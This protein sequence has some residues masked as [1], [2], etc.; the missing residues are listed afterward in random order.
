MSFD[1][2]P[3]AQKAANRKPYKGQS[4][5]PKSR[6]GLGDYY[7]VAFPAKLAKIRS[8]MGMEALSSK[9]MGTPPKSLA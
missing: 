3:N 6:K 5:T 7:G 1:N 9:K 8:G 2:W 4:H